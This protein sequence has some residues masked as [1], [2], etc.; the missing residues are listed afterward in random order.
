[1]KNLIGHLWYSECIGELTRFF[2]RVSY[3]HSAFN[4]ILI[5]DFPLPDAFFETSSSL[6]IKTPG[7]NIENYTGYDFFMD[8]DL[9]RLD[10]QQTEHLIA[11]EGYN[12][13]KT[14]GY[15]RLSYHLDAFKPTYPAGNGDTLLDIC[16]S[17]YHFLGQSW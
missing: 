6:L 7:M 5:E 4:W 8:L 10:G 15:C 12:P 17:V 16:Q 9:T 13:H 11:G 2:D 1:M 14:D 3:D